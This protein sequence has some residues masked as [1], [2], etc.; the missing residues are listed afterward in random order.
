MRP[1]HVPVGNP[2]EV[3]ERAVRAV[4]QKQYPSEFRLRIFTIPATV[5]RSGRQVLLH[6]NQNAPWADLLHDAV[7]RLRLHPEPG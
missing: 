1:W 3:R 7:H 6:L 4:A 2:R 5:A